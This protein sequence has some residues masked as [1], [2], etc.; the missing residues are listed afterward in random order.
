MLRAGFTTPGNQAMHRYRTSL[1]KLGLILGSVSFYVL[2][3]ALGQSSCDELAREKVCQGHREGFYIPSLQTL[4]MMPISQAG[5]RFEAKWLGRWSGSNPSIGQRSVNG[6]LIDCDVWIEPPS[7][8][9]DDTSTESDESHAL[10]WNAPVRIARWTASVDAPP[11]LLQSNHAH[12]NLAN[13]PDTNRKELVSIATQ[14]ANVRLA[15]GSVEARTVRVTAVSQEANSP[16]APR[17]SGEIKEKHLQR[18][19]AGYSGGR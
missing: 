8:E 11:K 4:L 14:D 15:S 5:D 9:L 6:S 17:R 12:R 16:A 3:P 1:I 18:K 19:P 2:P 13:E 7:Y 10:E